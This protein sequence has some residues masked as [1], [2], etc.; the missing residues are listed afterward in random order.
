MIGIM[1]MHRIYVMI[2]RIEMAI[3]FMAAV[4]WSWLEKA[5]GLHDEHNA[6]IN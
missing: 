4:V 6:R 5:A 1:R 3:N 2:D